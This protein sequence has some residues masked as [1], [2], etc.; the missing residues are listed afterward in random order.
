MPGNFYV[1]SKLYLMRLKIWFTLVFVFCGMAKIV[2]QQTFILKGVISKKQTV[3][4]VSQA[5]V[6]NL[7]SK[8]IMM[9][10]EIGWF[11]IKAAIGDTIMFTKVDFTEQKIVVTGTS[12]IGVYMQPI[13]N[14]SEVVIKGQTKKQEIAEVMGQ[15]RSQGT[16]YNGKPPVSTFLTNPLTGLYELFGKTPK[17]AKRFAAYSKNEE[18]YAEVRK[19]YNA[20]FVVR[21][22]NTNDSLAKKFIEY[23]TIDYDDMKE[24][25]DYELVKRVKEAFDYYIKNKDSMDI[26]S[27]TGPSLIKKE[28]KKKD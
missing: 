11:S 14:L 25:N 15:Y 19:R 3:E 9:S 8:D 10:D 18:Q 24:M 26:E 22:C 7:H 5:L 27:I 16:Y 4:R 28:T 2:A 20:K 1:Y 13:I 17:D 12:D 21:V 6:T 23:Y